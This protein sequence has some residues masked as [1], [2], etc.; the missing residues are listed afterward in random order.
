MQK[1]KLDHLLTSFTRID[2]KW[3]KDLNVRLKTIKLLEENIGI[4]S[5]ILLLVIYFQTYLLEQEKQ[6]EK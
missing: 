6:K 5:L 4:I 1:N 3:I 2:S